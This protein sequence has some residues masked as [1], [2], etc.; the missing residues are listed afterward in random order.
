MSL[1]GVTPSTSGLAPGTLQSSS[2]F[3]TN[4]TLSAARRGAAASSQPSNELSEGA[5]AG[6]VIGCVVG[7]A[8]LVAAAVIGGRKY[9]RHRAGWRKE[10]MAGAPGVV[11]QALGIVPMSHGVGG[12][13][14]GV[15][16]AGYGPGYGQGYGGQTGGIEMLQQNAVNGRDVV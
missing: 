10:H 14:N 13:P 6:I 3:P 8:L 4:P 5:I 11:D 12:A 9:M 2:Q 7:A 1:A 15:N 16:G